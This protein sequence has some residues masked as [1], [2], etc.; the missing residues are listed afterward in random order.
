MLCAGPFCYR[1]YGPST[2]ME[3]GI[4]DVPNH[5]LLGHQSQFLVFREMHTVRKFRLVFCVYVSDCMTPCALGV[6]RN[7]LQREE[8][9]GGFEYLLCKPFVTCEGRMLRTYSGD[10]VVGSMTAMSPASPL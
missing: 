8:G 5:F 7:V 6:L 9:R 1:H 4:D 10:Y 2:E 3:P